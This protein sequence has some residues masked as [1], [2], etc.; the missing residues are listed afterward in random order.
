AP[1]ARRAVL[2]SVVPALA[3]RRV[4][5]R[6]RKPNSDEPRQILLTPAR[7]PL[8]APALGHLPGHALRAAASSCV[9]SLGNQ[10]RYVAPPARILRQS[11]YRRMGPSARSRH[12]LARFHGAR[13]SSGDEALMDIGAQYGQGYFPETRE[14]Q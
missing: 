13:R 7:R 14:Q 3:S 4:D 6:R 10:A 1:R 8:Q 11:E 9:A 2:E 12:H 5:Q